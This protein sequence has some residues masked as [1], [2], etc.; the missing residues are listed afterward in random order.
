MD[1]LTFVALVAACAPQVD[2][3]TAHGLVSVESSFN[4]NAIGVVAGSL[5][6]Q[7]RSRAEALATSRQLQADGWNY[8]VGLGQINARNFRRL[9]LTVEAAFEPCANLAAMQLL[10]VECFERASSVR[11]TRKPSIRALTST[12]RSPVSAVGHELTVAAGRYG[13]SR[14]SRDPTL[15]INVRSPVSRRRVHALPLLFQK[16]ARGQSD[17]FEPAD[18]RRL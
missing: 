11:R 16:R 2:T 17:S 12:C 8:S 1:T 4:A 7:P 6:R 9:G 15:R 13:A 5:V 3:G 18:E 14:G 10:L